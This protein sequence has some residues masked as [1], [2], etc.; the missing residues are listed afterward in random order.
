MSGNIFIYIAVMALTTYLI[1][2]LPT[3]LFRKKITSKFVKSFLF[4]VTYAVLGAM[5]VPSVFYSTGN[6]MTAAAGF[7]VAVILAFR[8]KSLL[9]VAIAACAAA[10]AVSMIC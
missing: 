5:T 8:E 9:T 2:M 6:V 4:Y 1:R 7:I 10:F 3:V